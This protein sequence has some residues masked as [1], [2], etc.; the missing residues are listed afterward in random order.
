[1]HIAWVKTVCGR[2]KSDYRYSNGIVYNNFPW[3]ENSTD[4]QIKAIETAAQKVLDAR[5]EFP[6]SKMADLYE[7]D[8]MPPILI[9]AH[10]DLDKAVDLAYRPQPFTSEANRMVFLFEIYEKYTADLFTK[11]RVKKPKSLKSK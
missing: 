10:S 5:A 7:P 3:P 4:K 1:M 11:E 8:G 2:L 6:K 9:K